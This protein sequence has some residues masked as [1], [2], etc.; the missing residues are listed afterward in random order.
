MAELIWS[1][2]LWDTNAI[3]VERHG[4]LLCFA[5]KWLGSKKTYV[6]G[7]NDFKGYKRRSGDDKALCKELFCLL[8]EAEAVVCHNG[9]SFD[10][11]KINYRFL[12]NGIKYPS[13]YVKIDT[14]LEVK[15]IAKFPSHKLDDLGNELKFGRKL[16]HEGWSLWKGCYNG[17]KRSWRKMKAYNKVDVELLEK[18]YLKLLPWIKRPTTSNLTNKTR[19]LLNYGSI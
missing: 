15:K 10:L 2:E 12:V 13:P 11:K 14:K 5:Y 16:K 7:L 9:N 1:W 18:L 4:H 17:D 19:K 6:R 3:E 8:N